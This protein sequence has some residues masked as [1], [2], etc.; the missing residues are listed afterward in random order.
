MPLSQALPRLS[1]E[2]AKGWDDFFARNGNN[3]ENSG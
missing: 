3:F 1:P 2:R